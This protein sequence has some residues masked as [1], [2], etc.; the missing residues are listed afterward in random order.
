MK[1]S[2]PEDCFVCSSLGRVKEKELFF[3]DV[4]RYSTFS[5]INHGFTIIKVIPWKA[6]IAFNEEIAK[7]KR[8]DN[9]AGITFHDMGQDVTRK[10]QKLRRSKKRAIISSTTTSSSLLIQKNLPGIEEWFKTKVVTTV[11]EKLREATSTKYNLNEYTL[12]CNV[13][14]GA[15]EQEV[16]MDNAL[17]CDC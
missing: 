13:K 9:I 5:L 1:C 11:E 4:K 14:F 3:D 8:W 6:N 10:G 7:L 15:N 12:F 2:W 16:H 17:L